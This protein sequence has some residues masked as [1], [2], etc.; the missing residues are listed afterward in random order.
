MVS[1]FDFFFLLLS[2]P[3]PLFSPFSF[4][5]SLSLH[6]LLGFLFRS[7]GLLDGYGPTRGHDLQAAIRQDRIPD[8]LT[9]LF[10]LLA[11]FNGLRDRTIVLA[12]CFGALRREFF[13]KLCFSG[14]PLPTVILS[15]P[16]SG[17]Y[18][19]RYMIGKTWPAYDLL[20]FRAFPL[21][22]LRFNPPPPPVTCSA[23]PFS[24]AC[25]SHSYPGARPPIFFFLLGDV[26]VI[27]CLFPH[28][29]RPKLSLRG[30][31]PFLPRGYLDTRVESLSETL[32]P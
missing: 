13:S 14:T 29:L 4:S 12:A 5:L 17:K 30:P 24:R 3:L 26:T 18:Y 10:E 11:L 1:S 25:G 6:S 15:A 8:L 21:H 27:I 22:D 19:Q 28:V 16:S 31:L 2:T 20:A 32:L 23:A 9:W 7:K